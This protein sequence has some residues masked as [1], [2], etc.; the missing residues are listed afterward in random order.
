M[1]F[2]HLL[3]V[4]GYQLESLK[5]EH[6]KE[7]LKQHIIQAGVQEDLL[8]GP[9]FDQLKEVP[10]KESPLLEALVDLAALVEAVLVAIEHR[11]MQQKEEPPKKEP[12]S[13]KQKEEE[14]R[15]GQDVFPQKL[16]FKIS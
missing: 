2:L 14:M 10:Q 13:L 6:N 8:A 16:G 15:Q 1:A 9:P 4:A 7:D 3:E 5:D 12:S 11:Q